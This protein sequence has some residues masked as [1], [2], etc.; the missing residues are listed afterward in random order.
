MSISRLESPVSQRDR[1][2]K[3]SALSCYLAMTIACRFRTFSFVLEQHGGRNFLFFPVALFSGCFPFCMSSVHFVAWHH[4]PFVMCPHY[5]R[6]GPRPLSTDGIVCAAQPTSEGLWKADLVRLQPGDC[7]A[8]NSH[9]SVPASAS[10]IIFFLWL[11]FIQFVLP[12]ALLFPKAFP[13]VLILKCSYFCAWLCQVLEPWR[14][15][16]TDTEWVLEMASGVLGCSEFVW[17]QVNLSTLS[18]DILEGDSDMA[19]NENQ[20]M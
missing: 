16:N 18:W 19:V 9:I 15:P 5:K 13:P 12:N 11:Y 10:L 17:F 2:A 6:Q 4:C 8:V 3:A 7:P 20:I 14:I 1:G